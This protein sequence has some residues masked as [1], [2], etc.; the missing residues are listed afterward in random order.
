MSPQD[1]PKPFPVLVTPRLVLRSLCAED[2][3]ALHRV[4][5]EPAVT[6]YLVL[7]PFSSLGETEGMMRILTDLWPFG[8]GVRWV[9]EEEG[10]VLGTCGFHNLAPEH[11]RAEVG[12]EMA[13]EA[14]GRGL[15]SEALSAVLEFGFGTLGFHRVEAFVNRGNRRSEALLGRLGFHHDGC[16]R[17]YEFSR[18]GFVDQECHSLLDREWGEGRGALLPS[19]LRCGSVV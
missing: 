4:W 11:R 8:Q 9:L 1:S 17:D 15:M 18:G 3:P 5:T 10:R 16:L 19:S 7:T 2:A 12:Y 6:E 14:W 13:S